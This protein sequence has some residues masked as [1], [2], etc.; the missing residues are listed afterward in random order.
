VRADVMVVAAAIGLGVCLVTLGC[1]AKELP[2][3]TV[4][5]ISTIAGIFEFCLKNAH[6]FEFG[7]SKIDKEK[8]ED[9]ITFLM[10]RDGL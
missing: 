4:G 6:T 2:G 8:T 3:E 10:E 1:F 7:S 9:A 5:T